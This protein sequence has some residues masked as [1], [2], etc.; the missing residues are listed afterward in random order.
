MA[1]GDISNQLS[2]V[3]EGLDRFLEALD[4][5]SMGLG[6]QDALKKIQ[7]RAE[8]KR[9]DQEKR[10]KA[11][12][13]KM[14]KTRLKQL[15]ES[16]KSMK[17][18]NKNMGDMAKKGLGKG[19]GM[20][21]GAMKAGV[22]GAAV[23]AVKFL[24][25]A[26]LKM[27]GLM[28]GLSKRTGEFRSNLGNVKNMI[29]GLSI[30]PGSMEHLGISMDQVGVEATNLIQHLGRASLLTKD[31][32]ELSLQMQ[33]G[34]GM[35]AESVGQMIESF[36][37][38]NVN[39]K[40][41]VKELRT[42]AVMAGTNVGLV[43]R[44]VATISKDIAI[45]NSRSVE[46]FKDMAIQAAQAGV[47][48]EELTKM[49]DA[50]MDPQVIG[51]NIG[52][53][54]QRLGGDFAKMNP[55]TLWNLADQPGK[56]EDLNKMVIGS[57]TERLE[58]DKQG[59]LINKNTDALLRKS[60]LKAMSDYSGLTQ[61]ALT[62]IIKQKLEYQ[63]MEKPFG[64][65][66]EDQKELVDLVGTGEKGFNSMMDAIL[67]IRDDKGNQKYTKTQAQLLITNKNITK[68]IK[69]QLAA[70]KEAAEASNA[71]NKT[72]KDSQTLL[73]LLKN[74]FM[75]IFNE[76]GTAASLALGVEG[77]EEGSLGHAI[78]EIGK[79]VR[80]ILSLDTLEGDIESTSFFDA[81]KK[82]FVPLFEWVGAELLSAITAALEG[83]DISIW[84]GLIWGDFVEKK[85]GQEGNLA[86]DVAVAADAA[87]GVVSGF[88]NY[89]PDI[90][91]AMVRS[92][93]TPKEGEEEAYKKTVERMGG[94]TK[95]AKGGIVT[96]PT[97]ALIGEA[98]PELVLP[99]GGGAK[100]ILPL[101]GTQRFADGGDII[102]LSSSMFTGITTSGGGLMG[103]GSEARRSQVGAANMAESKRQQEAAMNYWRKEYDRRLEE[104]EERD[105][106]NKKSWQDYAKQFFLK[107][108]KE[109]GVAL[110]KALG[111]M[112]PAGKEISSALMTGMKAWSS[113]K[114]AKEALSLGVRAGL[115]EA[116]KEGGTMD[117]FFKRHDNIL[118]TGLQEGLQ[119]FARTGNIKQAGRQVVSGSIN[120]MVKKYL[121]DKAMGQAAQYMGGAASGTV[122]NR[123]GLFMAGEGG[124][125]EVIVP[126]DRIRKGL[127]ID[128]GVAHELS[129]IGVPG[130]QNGGS[131]GDRYF[132]RRSSYRPRSRPR[133]SYRPRSASGGYY[134]ASAAPA[135]QTS[136]WQDMGGAGGIGKAGAAAGLMT[137][138]NTFA[139]GGSF[140]QAAT[141]GAGTAA[142]AAIGMGATAGLSLIP[143]VGPI[144][145]PILGPMIGQLAGPLITKGLNKMFG[146]AGGQKK[147]RRRAAKSIEQ[148]IKSGGLFDFG[149]PSG[150]SQNI[151]L[152]IGGKE[153]KPTEANYQKLV[154]RLN[155]IKGL[156]RAG[157]DAG[158]MIGLATGK[159]TGPQAM[160]T[161]KKMNIAL[162]GSAAGDK[163]MKAVATPQ[164]QLASGGIVTRPTSAI[165]GESGPEMV[166]PLHEQRQ[167]NENLVK[168]MKE[169]NKLMKLM[170]QTQK[171]TGSTEIIMDGRKVAE[172][173]SNN[174]YDI[175]NGI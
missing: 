75:S 23:I 16:I 175:G 42:E 18:F 144:I 48:V 82:R 88:K 135:P 84:R 85:T 80:S 86:K 103:S 155:K 147:G 6:S 4:A 166:I 124:N 31:M 146:M 174:F 100:R 119:T 33:K 37:R 3:S 89:T 148:H 25:D 94:E 156:A 118:M 35:T 19:L 133:Y 66:L 93:Y 91:E 41:F 157:V 110:G 168:E 122:V 15:T 59:N 97:R 171:E 167:A 45:Q 64:N 105:K 162:Y 136:A 96:R 81:M 128:S 83:Y 160:D 29:K 123:P 145:G 55:F 69:D 10:F 72:I 95:L 104:M 130:F 30:G 14:E 17:M 56:I 169:Q 77:R 140:G 108:E 50:F 26:F 32:I 173:V 70:R 9:L 7:A 120:A 5:S 113:G 150:L 137:F 172:T 114:S 134:S 71:L 141:A 165:V 21:K 43:M 76:I 163:Y 125:R 152:A 2:G 22:I 109:V 39:V 67:A 170:I 126:T 87:P 68:E 1:N 28:A 8:M 90:Q 92:G 143:G 121:G 36:T 79:E 62:R 44:N 57:L 73:T 53:V 11:K 34:F 78:S 13:E 142:G 101:S 151:K 115:N 138:A 47:G 20:L 111:P 106:N 107:Y 63:K 52:K 38:L 164:V 132:G 74:E 27:D 12:I 116:M 112:G 153:N 40:E 161:Y 158:T 98:G 99:L 60:T 117:K 46:Y 149:Q 51:E 61:E 139:Q 24:V 58:L 129:S 154:D 131:V 127:P 49:G 54:A 65:L 159:I 102:P